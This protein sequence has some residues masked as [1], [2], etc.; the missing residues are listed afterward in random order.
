[1]TISDD[2]SS[3]CNFLGSFGVSSF[4]SGLSA[5]V[6][7]FFLFLGTP[8]SQRRFLPVGVRSLGGTEVLTLLAGVLELVGVGVGTE[9]VEFFLGL[10]VTGVLG[11]LVVEFFRGRLLQP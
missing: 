3:G 7:L 11:V 8:K 4:F 2:S 9:G 1:M 5:S 6:S 10:V